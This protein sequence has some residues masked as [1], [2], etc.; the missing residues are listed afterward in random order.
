MKAESREIVQHI[1]G[2]IERFSA[3]DVTEAET[4]ASFQEAAM[5]LFRYQFQHNAAYKKYG[6]ARRKSPLTV[7]DW[8]EIPPI[9]IQAF[10][11]LTLS[12]EPAEEA[13]AVFMTSG[14]TNADKRGKH[15]HPTLEVWD[16]SMAPPFKHYVL[17]DRDQITVLVLSPAADLNRNSSLSRYLTK[18][19]EHYGTSGSR[20]FY[21][22]EGGLD[23]EGVLASLQE[24]AARNEPVL[25]IGATFA[26][27][28][29]LDYCAEHSYQVELPQGSRLFDTGGLKGQSRE[30]AAEELY[31]KIEGYFGLKR[32][33]CVNMYG[34]TELSS[35]IYDQTI[36]SSLLT[37][38]TVHEKA[39][40]PWIRTLV[41]H[42]DSLE[43]VPDGE[44]G[45]LAHYD[46]GSWNSAFAVLT[47]DMGYKNEHGLVLLG[48][49]KG[50]EARGCSIAIDQLMSSNKK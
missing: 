15:Y 38:R 34:M 45:V 7:R 42:P 31:Q 39:N 12:C 11:E 10:K 21:S 8:R 44:T 6:Q 26:Y 37:G 46:L 35:Q 20:F 22:Q 13:E 19:V 1:L 5:K 24:C 50:S 14:T 3:G 49:I 30:I 29:L 17:P 27:V 43:P 41:L 48:R 16:A 36:R 2:Y 9:P 33:S 25:L 40:P 47:E 18:A 28:H 4:E 32:E 23:M